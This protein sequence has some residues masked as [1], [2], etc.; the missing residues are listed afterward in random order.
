MRRGSRAEVPALSNPF[1]NILRLSVG[2]FIAKTLT[3][4]AFVWLA[5]VLG[6][7]NFGV[8][9]FASSLL[10]WFLLLADGGIELWAT[11]EAARTPD[12]PHL[13]A[14]VM[15]LRFL[16]ATASFVLLFLCLPVLPGGGRLRIVMALFGLCLFAQA[17]SLKW[18]FLGREQMGLIARLLVAGQFIFAVA[19]FGLIRQ[20][21][22]V[23][24]V[25]LVKFATDAG[26]ALGFAALYR[27]QYGTLLLRYTFSGARIALGPALTMG[28]TQ[29]MG[30]L[31]FNFDT[32]LIG[33]LLGLTDV[34][35]YT[36]AYKPVTTLLQVPLTYFSGV[37]PVLARAWQQG[38]EML[39]P[40]AER[41]LHWC[42][43]LAIPAGVGGT[44]LAG[45]IIQMLFGS[46]Y[47][48]SALPFSILIWSGVLVVVRGTYRHGLIAA[49]FQKLE[50]QNGIASSIVNVGLNVLL[51][52]RFGMVAAACVT[53][54]ADLLWFG[55]AARQFNRNL[56]QLNLLTH[57]WRPIA[58]ATLM[59]T[60]LWLAPVNPWMLRAAAGAMVYGVAL[61]LLGER[62]GRSETLP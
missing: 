20:P 33:F 38:P 7:Q 23:L 28:V 58:A 25:P 34:G 11:R 13:V 4:L 61:L 48:D 6:V 60:F 42:C 3:F 51:I 30:L 45:P 59:G 52:P 37:F 49:G 14:R 18:L 56:I 5:R 27:R 46:A 41:S 40:I 31:N 12:V 35:L 10:A 15:P 19:I 47:A 17:A 50:L 9:E 36:A 29:A 43:L 16:L 21:E 62:F 26:T 53:V 57:A 2:D 44:L 55:L 22:H 39:R 32:L 24:W 1:R 8:L 54:I